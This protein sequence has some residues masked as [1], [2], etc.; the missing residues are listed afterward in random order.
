MSNISWLEYIKLYKRG[1]NSNNTHFKFTGIKD[2]TLKKKSSKR[3]KSFKP[4]M[5][6][7]KDNGYLIL[8]S[9][10]NFKPWKK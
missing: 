7:T 2:Y 4:W 10:D 6:N 8:P 5:L 1:R 9:I 3:K